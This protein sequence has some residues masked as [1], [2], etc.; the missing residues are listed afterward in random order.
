MEEVKEI[1][2]IIEFLETDTYGLSED[3]QMII[4]DCI[5]KLECFKTDNEKNEEEY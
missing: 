4:D 1:D 3:A 2:R 5:E